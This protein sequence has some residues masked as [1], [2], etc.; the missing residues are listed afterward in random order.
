MNLLDKKI[1]YYEEDI[2]KLEWTKESMIEDCSR[3]S[4]VSKEEKIMRPEK[5]LQ[6]EQVFKEE[7]ERKKGIMENMTKMRGELK[8]DSFNILGDLTFMTDAEMH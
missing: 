8:I 5:L 1:K 4:A 6:I 3:P 7:I 2:K